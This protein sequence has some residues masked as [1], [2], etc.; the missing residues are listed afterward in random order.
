MSEDEEAA[1]VEQIEADLKNLFGSPILTLDQLAVALNYKSVSALRQAITRN[2]FHVPLF[3]MP[4]R[5]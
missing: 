1:L 3:T 4:N 5:R 2:N